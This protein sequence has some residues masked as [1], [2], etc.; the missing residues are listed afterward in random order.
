MRVKAYILSGILLSV[1]HCV[2]AGDIQG[3]IYNLNSKNDSSSDTFYS[4]N[5]GTTY[6]GLAWGR[7]FTQSYE[8]GTLIIGNTSKSPTSNGH[9]FGRGGDVGFINGTFNAKEVYITGTLGSGNA[10]R[11][12]GGANLTFNASNNLTLDGANI[13]VNRAGT[14][15]STTALNG[16]EIDIKNSQFNIENINGGGI[17]IGNE[18]TE[19][20]TIDNT[21]ISMSGGQINITAKNS[22]LNFGSVNITNGT[23]DLTK[24]NYTELTTHSLN[25]TNSSF[26]SNE[27]NMSGD[28]VN[29]RFTPTQT[30]A[31]GAGFRQSLGNGG[32]FTADSITIDDGSS[33][34]NA[35]NATIKELNFKG[36]ST[37]FGST[38]KKLT[39]T[40]SGKL[41]ITTLT[42]PYQP[43]GKGFAAELEVKQASEV[44]ID[45]IHHQNYTGG[46]WIHVNVDNKLVVGNIQ[47]AT[48]G[49]L[50][51]QGHVELKSSNGD[52]IV[53]N[54]AGCGNACTGGLGIRPLNF[55]KISGKNFYGGNIEAIGL[56]TAGSNSTLDLTGVSG[57]KFIDTF[58]IRTGTLQA[59]DFHVNNFIVYKSN[60]YSVVDQNIGKSFINYLSMEIG[61]SDF[62]DGADIRFNG[63]GEILNFN[64]IDARPTSFVRMGEIK[65]VN[66]N[67]M[68]IKEA[69]VNIK[70]GIFNTIVSQKG[71][72]AITNGASKITANAL[73]VNELLHLKDSSK[74]SGVM[75]IELNANGE[76]IDQKFDKYLN[77]SVDSKDLK[78]MSGDEIAKLIESNKNTNGNNEKTESDYKNASG[79]YITTSDGKHY[80]VLPDIMTNDNITNSTGQVAN[81]GNIL[82]EQ[83]ELTKGALNNYGKI[84]I[85]DGFVSGDK[86]T[87]YLTG[88]LNNYNTIDL[89]A[90][91]HIE[92]TGNFNNKGKILFS[93]QANPNDSSNNE[94]KNASMNIKGKATLD[95]SPGSTGAL[96]ADIA[97][98]KTLSSIS[99]QLN[100][101]GSKGV[102]YNLI[103]AESI[104]YTYTQGDYTTT[105]D[106]SNGNTTIKTEHTNGGQ[107]TNKD[108]QTGSN[109][110]TKQE[111][112]FTTNGKDNPW[113]M[114]K[115]QTDSNGNVVENGIGS[116]DN[117]G[118]LIQKPSQQD[119]QEE[120]KQD[121]KYCG[122]GSNANATEANRGYDYAQQKMKNSFSLTYK[123]GSIDGKYIDI[124]KVVND[125]TIGFKINK[126]DINNFIE[127]NTEKP[128]CNAESS[129]FDC[130]LYMEA[131]GNNSWI[132]AIKKESANSYEILKNLFYDDK[133]SLVFLINLDQTLAASRNLEYFLE[134]G[135]TLDTAIDH[136]SNLENKASTLH[137]LTLSMESAKLNRL[138]R[139]ASI[140]GS[141]SSYIAMQNYQKNLEAALREAE[142]LKLASLDSNTNTRIA[143]IN[144]IVSGNTN[145]NAVYRSSVATLASSSNTNTQNANNG[146]TDIQSDVTTDNNS[147][148]VWFDTLADLIMRF[149]NREEYPNHAWVNMLGNLNFSKTGSAQLYGF[150]AGYDYFVD[151][152]Q[153]AFGAYGGYGYGTFNGN[154]NGF[155]SNNSNNMFAGIYTRTFIENHEID[156]TLNTAFSF[157]NEKQNSQINNFD[158]LALFK[159]EY[160]YTL[161]NVDLNATYGYAFLMKKGYIVKPFAGLSYYV[162]GSSG[163]KRKSDNTPIFAM[164]TDDNIRQTISVNIGI[165]GRKYFANQSYIFIV[166]QLKQDA[167]ILQNNVDSSGT[168][169]TSIGN[170]GDSVNNFNMRYKAQGYKSYVFLTGGGEYSFGRWYLNG[171]LSLQSSV[172]DKNFGLGF[173]IGGRVVF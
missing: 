116:T 58:S 131:G 138:A 14:Q 80:L 17:N 173:N 32:D 28:I 124:E 18:K 164:N 59:K 22:K 117:E 165:D 143:A 88:N 109:G 76:N 71:Q 15:N 7:D 121:G 60:S 68:K 81:G 79:T 65:H 72:T 129:T 155:T 119:K 171:S 77:V 86:P 34:L 50:G 110:N 139:V 122:F 9:W 136:V 90:N 163:F 66:V 47:F 53:K 55:L 4:N 120:C 96:Q 84:L 25:I 149:N 10:A 40:I 11:T 98:S 94:I 134:V 97:D 78:N 31:H 108:C 16:K 20:L 115:A 70:N 24:A 57:T 126:V 113:D 95:I 21:N 102:E 112:D 38:Q 154:N 5:M 87:L 166:A 162:L 114:D 118:N 45:N 73:N 2:Y 44:N 142:K 104:S 35:T 148:E 62:A 127:G 56:P 91:G 153:T 27:L 157:T 133:S 99:S 125:T 106:K 75:K 147:N 168:T 169:T 1:S 67:E 26:R 85:D 13:S 167:I 92:V 146:V 132:N 8:N 128:L 151:K 160:S 51:S 63:G 61:T 69:E 64:F 19:N 107:C 74:H 159:D 100:T 33:T 105:F 137:T 144:N 41:N 37:I 29:G 12:G 145:S 49:I 161:S 46:S 89:G 93:I 141:A 170:I 82:I 156:V 52:V 30:L 36:P 130:A 101:N 111:T 140:H 54:A 152:L 6:T 3:D 83:T 39:A 23:L 172:F 150:N 158:L 43:F 103:K 48:D 123:G 42:N 135:R